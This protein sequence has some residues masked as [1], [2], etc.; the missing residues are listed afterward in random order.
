[1]K[2]RE[3]EMLIF[4][5]GNIAYINKEGESVLDSAKSAGVFCNNFCGGKGTCGKCKVKVEIGE[6]NEIS[7]EEK[8]FL[9]EDEIK[10][11]YRLACYLYP[12]F[13]FK[14]CE[15][16]F[17]DD[18]ENEEYEI[19]DKGK[20]IDFYQEKLDKIFKGNHTNEG[21]QMEQRYGI[22]VDVGTTNIEALLWRIDKCQCVGRI[23][24]KNPQQRYGAD[25]VARICYANEKEINYKE[26]CEILQQEIVGM[27]RNFEEY[28]DGEGIEKIVIAGNAVMMHF[29][30]E[31][32]IDGFVKAPYVGSY[33]RGIEMKGDLWGIP[34]CNMIFF[35]NIESFVGADTVGVIYASW[36]NFKS[37][38]SI[39]LIDIGTNGELVM[40]KDEKCYV[41]S[42]AAGPAFEGSSITFGMRAEKGAIFGISILPD[43]VELQVIG[44][45]KPKGICGSGLVELVAKL[46]TM[47]V[48]DKTGYL[49]TREEAKNKQL[50]V[51]LQERLISNHH[52]NSFVLFQE[53]EKLVYLSQK[54]IR[55]LQLAKAAILSGVETL[56]EKCKVSA[57]DIEKCYLAGAFGTYLDKECGK[58]IGLLPNISTE[59]FECIGNAALFGASR[60]LFENDGFKKTTGIAEAAN[61]IVLGEDTSFQE[62]YILCMDFP[63]I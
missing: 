14:T 34:D 50:P 16:T 47:G 22:A 41:A 1:M 7:K 21:F 37:S 53:G 57:N 29:L 36:D 61:H 9:G 32:P 62:R 3:E 17:T 15:I 49:C 35:P 42:T 11:G 2:Y 51:F 38:N 44:G 48:I 28:I 33:K 10:E 56:L 55:E 4:Q 59:K 30:N 12:R 27:V 18:T 5:P 46:Y 23:V 39:L 31:C 40:W 43:K 54:D 60:V 52:G 63:S 58:I 20:D 6:F 45:E 24:K 25:V 8:N 26:L 19:Q 13:L